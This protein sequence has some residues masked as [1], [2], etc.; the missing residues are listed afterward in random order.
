[1]DV[2]REVRQHLV[3]D[4]AAT[5]AVL[6]EAV[7]EE[8]PAYRDLAPEQ[9]DEVGAIAGWATSRVLDLWVQ[10][11]TLGAADLDRFKGIGAARAMDGR[12]L[13]VVLRAYRVAAARAVD[14]V[15]ER[16]GDRLGVAD[17]LALTRLWLASVDALSEALYTGYQAASE[18][19]SGDHGR[20]LGDFL[21]DLLDG[22]QAT[23]AAI[24][25]RSAALGVHLPTPGWLLAVRASAPDTVPSAALD[26]LAAVLNGPAPDD[27]QHDGQPALA[28]AR[29][30]HAVLLLAQDPAARLDEALRERRWHGCL[31]AVTDPV[32]VPA[33]HR[34]VSDALVLAPGRA[35]AGRSALDE[36]DAQVLALL[37]ARPGADP[38]RVASA[39]L[40]AVSGPSSQ[41]LID[42]LDAFLQ[43]GSASEGAALLH[44]HPQT[45]RYRLRRLVALTGRDPRRPWDRFVLETA[46]TASASS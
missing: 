7:T 10:G 4:L 3:G 26:D 17:V 34:L 29:A 20:A 46:R 35:F 39:V 18:R 32:L 21:N 36:G 45:M 22:R 31:V 41:H 14:L 33:A 9:L 40:G 37:A 6:V 1:M 23:A 30:T 8:I 25:D 5:V 15:V 44:V 28:V 16:S 27:R 11:T 2:R 42:G 24:K 13:P 12:P 43:T 19:M 38:A